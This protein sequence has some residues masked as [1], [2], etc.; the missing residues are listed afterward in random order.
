M[1][2]GAYPHP[3]LFTPHSHPL[4]MQPATKLSSFTGQYQVFLYADT[5]QNASTTVDT[6]TIGLTINTNLK[7]L[8]LDDTDNGNHTV[9]SL[10]RFLASDKRVNLTNIEI[11]YGE[12]DERY[13][14]VGHVRLIAEDK[15]CVVIGFMND[16][17]DKVLAE[18]RYYAKKVADGNGFLTKQEAQALSRILHE[19]GGGSL[20]ANWVWPTS[21]DDDTDVQVNVER[22]KT[23]KSPRSPTTLTTPTS[24]TARQKRRKLSLDTD[25][26]TNGETIK[27]QALPATTRQTRR[28]VSVA[29]IQSDDEPDNPSADTGLDNGF[30]LRSRSRPTASSSSIQVSVEPPDMPQP[31]FSTQ[32]ASTSIPLNTLSS[33]L[34]QDIRIPGSP[35]HKR[36]RYA[37]EWWNV[38]GTWGLDGNLMVRSVLK[39][40]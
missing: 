7:V 19:V 36:I 5:N 4:V 21:A 9:A 32:A 38:I 27:P 10:G 31:Y 13:A 24:N 20:P 26:V 30:N 1:P 17:K 23:R 18:V 25:V 39:E 33:I 11:D 29:S 35:Y 2:V 22:N 8:E 12:G 37:G 3:P 6:A 14:D 16:V 40:R 15:I 28:K 34:Q